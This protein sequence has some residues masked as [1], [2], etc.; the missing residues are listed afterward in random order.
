[1]SD[2]K[3]TK[4]EVLAT[5]KYDRAGSESKTLSERSDGRMNLSYHT[6]V[7]SDLLHYSDLKLYNN[8]V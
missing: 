6:T 5:T 3:Y 2:D 8:Y 1:M 7:T 4:R